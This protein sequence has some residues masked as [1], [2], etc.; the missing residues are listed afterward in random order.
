MPIPNSSVLIKEITE[1]HIRT[2]YKTILARGTTQNPRERTVVKLAA[3]MRQLFKWA[4][5]RQ[6]W[7]SLLINGNPALLVNGGYNTHKNTLL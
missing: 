5:M 4:D 1:D 2:V 3:D 7:R 6:P